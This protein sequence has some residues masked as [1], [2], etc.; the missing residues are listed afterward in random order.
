MIV[1]P[2]MSSVIVLLF[3]KENVFTVP[4]MLT[5]SRIVLTP[6]LGYLVL[7]EYFA[8]ATGIFLIAGVT[9][10]VGAYFCKTVIVKYNLC[11]LE[12]RIKW[13]YLT[14]L[15]FAL[16]GFSGRLAKCVVEITNQAYFIDKA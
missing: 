13:N 5:M 12:F 4:N 8:M 2:V 14:P 16:I 3:Q 10:L 6:F 11:S 7:Q 15:K 9:D 1:S